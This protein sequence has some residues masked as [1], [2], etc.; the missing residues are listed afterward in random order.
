M[1][2][3]LGKIGF[4]VALATVIIVLLMVIFGSTD[5]SWLHE[6]TAAVEP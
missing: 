3:D 2:P 5:T 6:P 1:N 4:S